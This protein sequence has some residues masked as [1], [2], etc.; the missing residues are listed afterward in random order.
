MK[1]PKYQRAEM[2]LAVID[3][4]VMSMG[5]PI[6]RIELFD[7]GFAVTAGRERLVLYCVWTNEI[8][9]DGLPL[10]GSGRWIA[11]TDDG[12]DEDDLPPGFRITSPPE[13]RSFSPWRVFENWF[14][15]WR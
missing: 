14:R 11:R 8:S 4:A 10:L 13:Q 1:A 7:G 9:S 5:E 2:L 12:A 3:R 15:R 6:D